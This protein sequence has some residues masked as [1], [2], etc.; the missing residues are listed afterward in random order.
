M[1]HNRPT[2]HAGTPRPFPTRSEVPLTALRVP[3]STSSAYL[4]GENFPTWRFVHALVTKCLTKVGLDPACELPHW[5]KA[6]SYVRRQVKERQKNRQRLAQRGQPM[7]AQEQA[8]QQER[9]T[10]L[11]WVDNDGNS[12][13]RKVVTPAASAECADTRLGGRTID[14][15]RV[16]VSWLAIGPVGRFFT[17]VPVFGDLK[18]RATFTRRAPRWWSAR[19]V[20]EETSAW[21]DM[22]G[23]LRAGIRLAAVASV[24]WF[25]TVHFLPYPWI[26]IGGCAVVAVAVGYV[27]RWVRHRRYTAALFDR[28]RL[29]LPVPASEKARDWITVP[30]NVDMVR[31]RSQSVRVRIPPSWHPVTALHVP[32]YDDTG[33]GDPATRTW[34]QLLRVVDRHLPGEWD[35][36]SLSGSQQDRVLLCHRSPAAPPMY[37]NPSGFSAAEIPLG[38]TGGGDPFIAH[39]DTD[40]PHMLFA[41]PARWAQRMAMMPISHI[42]HHGGLVDVCAPYRV[43]PRVYNSVDSVRVHTDEYSMSDGIVQFAASLID[44]YQ[45]NASD[46]I[47]DAATR[48]RL[49]VLDNFD[50]LYTALDFTCQKHSKD[51]TLTDVMDLL[52]NGHTRGHF[53]VITTPYPH[54]KSL[55]P[56]IEKFGTIVAAGHHGPLAWRTMF[57]HQIQPAGY[58]PPGYAVAGNKHRIF[59]IRPCLITP[60][61]AR[62]TAHTPQ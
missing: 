49:L 48:T 32:E 9:T 40:C 20:S 3:T 12:G 5:E 29:I 8:E 24:A 10:T 59:D 15:M 19:Y 57:G 42:A 37:Y 34:E 7:R 27:R 36:A 60:S 56:F 47:N 54:M 38:S 43:L 31:D 51:A 17:G 62:A 53:L 26:L 14:A 55:T 41:G 45:T 35:H 1:Q 11:D 16:G 52:V 58:Y 44:A 23:W 18:S 39:L 21:W 6:W 25:V 61:I 33:D 22:P 46:Y 13:T 28:L 50:Q 30:R 4:R 2:G